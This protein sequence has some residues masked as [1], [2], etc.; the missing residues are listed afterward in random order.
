MSQS[1]FSES[2]KP[3]HSPQIL[4]T[5][6]QHPDKKRDILINILLFHRVLAYNMKGGHHHMTPTYQWKTIC[7]VKQLVQTMEHRGTQAPATNTNMTNG[8][9]SFQNPPRGVPSTTGPTGP[10]N[11]RY[12]Q[13]PNKRPGKKASKHNLNNTQPSTSAIFAQPSSYPQSRNLGTG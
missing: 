4:E 1:H 5:R 11:N 2:N 12:S 9:I 6:C 8:Q 13:P 7:E 3:L 10:S